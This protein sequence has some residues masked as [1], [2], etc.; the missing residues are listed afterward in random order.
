[1]VPSPISRHKVRVSSL[2][3]H[4]LVVW[5]IIN[6][7]NEVW[8]GEDVVDNFARIPVP[9]LVFHSHPF[10]SGSIFWSEAIVPNSV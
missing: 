3:V 6:T 10:R 8:I 7:I 5:N 9:K 1:M 4:E 2:A